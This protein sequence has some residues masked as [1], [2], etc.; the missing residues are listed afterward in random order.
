VKVLLLSAYD[1]DSHQSWRKGLATAFSDWEWTVLTLPPR[2]F[3]WR[4]R[5]N[6]LTWAMEQRSLLERPYDLLIV[7][8]MTDLSALRGFV[9]SLAS[10]PTI[11][12]FHE[13][14][15]GY[16]NSDKAHSS[17]EPQVLNLYTAL[18][19]DHI[20]FNSAYNRDTF[21]A[22]VEALLKRLPD[23]VPKNIRP[24]IEKRASVLPV[25]LAD[26][27]YGHARLSERERQALW[28][29]AS[30]SERAAL[31]APIKLLWAA[32]WEY[33]K[34][35][36][37][38]LAILDSLQAQKIDFRLCLLGQTFRQYPEAFDQIRERFQPQLVQYGYEES[39]ERYRQWLVSADVVLSTALHEFQ[40]LAV[41]EAMA[42]GCRPALPKR[43]A[44]PEWVSEDFLYDVGGLSLERQ[45]ENA[46]ELILSLGRKEL[47]VEIPDLSWSQLKSQY[48]DVFHSVVEAS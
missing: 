1:A 28:G 6:S 22:G 33:D 17:V 45:A 30:S 21:L 2:Y 26:S 5:G 42:A 24:S 37:L 7:T 36:D 12:Y 10:L 8:S 40:G 43:L 44:Y 15:F 19:A 4:I 11:V 20:L 29:D 38:L 3:S 9:P 39:G 48:A 31:A 46:L 34:G 13:N 16:P 32:R 47:S 27:C 18:C 41:L 35:P 25:P 23:H 14:Q